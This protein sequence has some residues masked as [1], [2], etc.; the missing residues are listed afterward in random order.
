MDEVLLRKTR[1]SVTV[2]LALSA[3]SD[4]A[5]MGPFPKVTKY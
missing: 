1:Q 4:A 3:L 2:T 5:T